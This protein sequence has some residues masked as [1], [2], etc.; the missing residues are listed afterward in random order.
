MCPSCGCPPAA[1][2]AKLLQKRSRAG[3]PSHAAA[4][5][6]DGRTPTTITVGD[7]TLVVGKGRKAQRKARQQ[8]QRLQELAAAAEAGSG[9]GAQQGCP[10]GVLPASAEPPEPKA[11]E[12]EPTAL[13]AL[14]DD[15]LELVLKALAKAGLPGRD[16]YL[17]EQQRRKDARLAFKPTW[18]K[19]KAVEAKWKKAQAKTAKAEAAAQAARAALEAAKSAL[20]KAE[21]AVAEAS[22]HLEV[23]RAEE[24]AARAEVDRPSPA[25]ELPADKP[26]DHALPAVQSLPAA[27]KQQPDV[28]AKLQQAERLLQEVLA[29]APREA[30]STREAFHRDHGSH[31]RAAGRD[32]PAGAERRTSSMP[33]RRSRSPARDL[34]YAGR[35]PQDS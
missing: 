30:A 12:A 28:A 19:V 29:G 15:E 2:A 23:A 5:S 8:M 32:A 26:P 18:L 7:F 11:M 21:A 35:R 16:E 4:K 24:A 25:A 20:A 17:A 14:G 33:A 27:Y 3:D 34:R 31:S 9:Q 13:R 10:A 22:G 1:A 6:S